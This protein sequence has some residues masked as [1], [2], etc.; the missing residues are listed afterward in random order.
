MT[1]HL[2][3]FS[4]WGYYNFHNAR[5]LYLGRVLLKLHR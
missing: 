3:P 4:T 5:A 2:L 1:I